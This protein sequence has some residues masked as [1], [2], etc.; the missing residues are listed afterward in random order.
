LGGHPP[1]GMTARHA[2][3]AGYDEVQHGN[4]RYSVLIACRA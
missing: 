1:A 3:A 4:C 2:V